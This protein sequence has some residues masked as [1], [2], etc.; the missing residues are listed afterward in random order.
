LKE[1]ILGVYF[2]YLYFTNM[3]DCRFNFLFLNNYH[4]LNILMKHA[5]I[6]FEFQLVRRVSI[7]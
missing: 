3:I 2:V 7:A 6:S 1:N 4:E 5:S